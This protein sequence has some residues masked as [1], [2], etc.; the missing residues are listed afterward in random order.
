VQPRIPTEVSA[1]ETT[2]DVNAASCS[3]PKIQSIVQGTAD[4]QHVGAVEEPRCAPEVAPAC[5]EIGGMHS[6]GTVTMTDVGAHILIS[7]DSEVGCIQRGFRKFSIS[8]FASSLLHLDGFREE[9]T[10]WCSTILHCIGL[11]HERSA[12]IRNDMFYHSTYEPLFM[13]QLMP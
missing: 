9:Q 6:I 1:T 7:L 13:Y 5:R 10:F 2:I 8:L 12:H 4:Q 3:I 11:R